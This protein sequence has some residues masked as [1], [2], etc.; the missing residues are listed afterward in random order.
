MREISPHHRPPRHSPVVARSRNLSDSDMHQL[1]LVIPFASRR[2]SVGFLQV[3]YFL[4]IKLVLFLK[5]VV[6]SSKN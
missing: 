3:D 6:F 1:Q 2:F 4:R 5:F